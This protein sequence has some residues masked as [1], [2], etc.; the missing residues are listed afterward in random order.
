MSSQDGPLGVGLPE[1]EYARRLEQRR[2]EA[3][4]LARRDER[5]A[6]ARLAS[7]AALV[8]VAALAYF[9]KVGPWWPA[10]P[11]LLFLPLV[12]WHGRVMRAR[13]RADRAAAFYEAGLDRLDDRWA[14][15]GESGLRFLDEAHPYAA[16]LDLFGAGSV[17]ER[18]CTAR[19]PS[20]QDTLAAWLLGPAPPAEVRARHAAID[21]LRPRLDLRE[22]LAL[23]GEDVSAGVPPEELAAWGAERPELASAML[24][25]GAA[26]LGGL[27][28]LAWVGWFF[29]GTGPWPVVA[30][31]AFNIGFALR[32]RAR[33]RRAL[34]TIGRRSRELTLLAEL[35]ARLE[36]EPFEAER[37]RRPHAALESAGRP[38]SRQIA[39]LASL[40]HLL[41]A[42][43]NQFFA[44]LAAMLLWTTQLALAIEAWRATSG[45]SIGRW[46]GAVGEIEALVALASYA[47]ECPDDP[48]PTV[49]E[50]PAHFVAER[51]GHPLI[52]AG[53]CVR[54]DV[55]LECEPRLLVVSGS[56]MS[57]KSTL[58]RTVGVN[59]VL[60]QAGAPVRAA[61]LRLSPLAVGATL[62]IQDS[63]QAG[64]SRFFAEI[65][66]VRQLVDLARGSP[67]L[68]FLLD[69]LF[70]GTNS[71]DR[72]HGA[73]AVV[74]SLL[75]LGAIGL[76]TTH[77]L[78]LAEIA[79]RLAPRAANVHFEDRLDDAGVMTFDYAM[80]PGVVRNSNALALMRAVGLDV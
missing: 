54:N 75:D 2:E 38:P 5:L 41:E 36:R 50:G 19:T 6:N 23:L 63:L 77:D 66:R 42:R 31:T 52:P 40:V 73:E 79:D 58:L 49:D 12:A 30:V 20:G 71:H 17:F 48:F 39:R 62:K 7:F 45:P 56:N 67:P 78:A 72:R 35:L 4:R 13:R 76:V 44:P 3:D 25:W 14:G 51:I 8:I 24:R 65:T 59:A 15:R 60:A 33:V 74:R 46:I 61:G 10:V 34:D 26:A 57:G 21:E 18:L 55:A 64:R 69:E 11:A 27:A 37:L 53:K 70:N 80:R 32:L 16:D 68:L 47:Y 9:R 29:V 22:D 43:E 1:P 28:V